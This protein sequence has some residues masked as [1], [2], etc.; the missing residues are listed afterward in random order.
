MFEKVFCFNCQLHSTRANIVWGEGNCSN[1]V[2]LIGEAPGGDEDSQGRPF[3]GTAGKTLRQMI[4]EAGLEPSQCRITNTVKCRPPNNRRPAPAERAA[5][6]THLDAEI[7]RFAPK[8]IVTV[9]LTATQAI[10]GSKEPMATL[11]EQAGSK[12]I[13]GYIAGANIPVFPCYHT[14]P[15]CV[16]RTPGAKGQIRRAI[17]LAAATTRVFRG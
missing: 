16:N 10:L 3:V 15:L 14:S 1:G 17:A 8:A 5:C 12:G 9:G 11:L 7:Q 13:D 6:R 4:E 2:M